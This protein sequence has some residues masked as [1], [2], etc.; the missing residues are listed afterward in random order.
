MTAFPSTPPAPTLRPAPPDAEASIPPLENGD[1]LT[2]TEFRRRYAAMP[3]VHKAEL[4]EGIVYMPSPVSTGRHGRPHV[5][6]STWFGYYLS[7]TPGLDVVSDNGTVRLDEDN[8]PQPDLFLCL[9]PKLG[10]S[11]TMDDEGYV[12]GPPT[13][14][15]EIASSSVSIDL[16][17]RLQV[18]RRNRVQE[19]VVWRTRD[20]A[21]D[22]FVLRDGHYVPQPPDADGVLRGEAFPGLWLDVAALL[23]RDL[24]K[25]FAA[26][27]RGAA[28]PEHALFVARLAQND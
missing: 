10:G 8:E 18:Y 12:N 11:T 16:N 4:I 25:L 15:M 9:P 14:A 26:V 13:L 28:S 27:D 23:A 17:A 24:P 20:R 22:W 7:K 1:R 19:Y 5:Y 21:V 6:A 2:A 3:G